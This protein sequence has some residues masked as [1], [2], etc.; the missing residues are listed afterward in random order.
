VD[1]VVHLIHL[2]GKR[3]ISLDGFLTGPGKTHIL[4]GEIIHSVS[5][6]PLAGAWGV[7]FLKLGKRVGMAI[8]VA[9]AA[10][11]IELNQAGAISKARL[12]LGSVA[13]RVVRSHQAESRLVGF[14]PKTAVLEK[15][16]R[17][18]QEDIAPISDIRSSAEYRNHSSVILARRVLE[19]AANHAI[20]RIA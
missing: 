6:K 11:A 20:R 1:A 3:S 18:C 19:V 5:F 12:C 2:S 13:P 9:N 17:A 7:A 16:A 14:Q 15:A 4:P 10:A 8:S